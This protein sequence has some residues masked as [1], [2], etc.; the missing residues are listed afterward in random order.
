MI[1]L[2]GL[3]SALTTACLFGLGTV[4]ARL[5]GEAFQPFFASWLALLGGGLC[6]CACQLLRRKPLL[7]HLTRACWVDLL[8]FAS[9]GTALPLVCLLFGLPQIGAIPGGFLLQFQ[10]PATLLFASFLLK[11]KIVWRQIAGVALLLAGSLLVILHDPLSSLTIK[12]DQGDLL[13]LIAAVAIGFSYIPG[14]RLSKHGDALQINLL[15][16]VGGSCFLF[17]LLLLQTRMLLA[18]LSWSLT[19]VLLLY[20]VVNFGLG[21][22]LLQAGLV[23]LQAWEVSAILQTVPL[24]STVFAVLLLHEPLT[25]NLLIGGCVVLIGGSLVI[26][27]SREKTNVESKEREKYGLPPSAD[28]ENNDDINGNDT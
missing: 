16:L 8:L 12:G 27:P 1:R 4:L 24:F 3:L 25:P 21:Y 13:V 28:S 2:R 22:L 19:G 7:P 9:I 11:E 20:T 6:L 14:K 10:T 5:I 18:P 23:L 17:P 15:R 26:L